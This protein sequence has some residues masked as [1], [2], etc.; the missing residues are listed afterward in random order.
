MTQ[1]QEL[2]RANARR[3]RRR[4]RRIVFTVIVIVVLVPILAVGVF[5]ARFD[6]NAYKPQIEQVVDQ[7]L[8]RRLTLNG[9]L[10]LALSLT[11]TITAED[12]ALANPPGFSRPEMAT[13][14]RLDA[15]LSL[16]PLLS[17]RLA[18][19]RI[20][21]VRPVI[22]VEINRAGETNLSFARQ[23]AS[24]AAPKG[25]PT[26]PT[27]ANIGQGRPTGH[28]VAIDVR[29]I[30]I[31]DGNLTWQDDRTGRHGALALASFT[32]TTASST[33]PMKLAAEAN[34]AGMPL[35]LRGQTGPLARLAGASAESGGSPWPVQLAFT[36]GT[37]QLSLD[38]MVADPAALRGYQVRLQAGLP[39][40]EALSPLFPGQKLPALH[41]V[42][43]AANL[44]DSGTTPR[45]TLPELSDV[46][47][48]AGKSDLG[49]VMPGLTL[50]DLS[51]TAPAL[52]QPCKLMLT[53]QVGTTPFSVSATLGPPA[54]LLPAGFGP[55][56]PAAP[57]PV[58]FQ[59]A[60]AGAN[61]AI[62]G[63]VTEPRSLAG[64]S[65]A[66]SAQVPDLAA[67]SPLVM[68]TLPSFA[69]VSFS[70]QITDAETGWR[71]WVRLSDFTLTLP[72][73]DLSG[74]AT[75]ALAGARPALTA[76]LTSK[77]L[78]LDALR[79]AMK[80]AKSG[81]APAA[82]APP[83]PPPV[84]PP[85][86][87]SSRGPSPVRL[88][89]DTPLPFATLK[90]ADAD[91]TLSIGGL[92]TGGIT[93]GNLAG[94][95]VLKDGNL[96]LAPFGVQAPGGHVALTAAVN[97]APQNP[98]VSLTIDAP[99]LA[100]SPLLK[101][102]G[103][104]A[105]ASGTVQ[106]QAHL[107]GAGSTPHAIASRLDGSLGV[108]MAGGSVNNDVIRSLLGSVLR[109]AEVPPALLGPGQSEVRCFA[110]RF[111]STNGFV[112]LRAF[113]LE[114][115]RLIITGGGG[116]ALGQE[117]LSL[118]LEPSY[119]YG[120]GAISL[121]VRVNG[122][123][124]DPKIAPDVGG[125]VNG[126]T[127]PNGLLAQILGALHGGPASNVPDCGPALALARF[128]APGP[129]APPPPP[130]PETGGKP[131]APNNPLNLLRGLFHQ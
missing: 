7:S 111:D 33:A 13:L 96:T 57:W 87:S 48:E 8:G 123:F 114:T 58:A 41:D 130:P 53:G 105:E 95:L 72:Q 15:Q 38:G 89:P 82:T 68:R 3:R 77:R 19:R 84:P 44:T 128:G 49:T 74:D 18:I 10:S 9:P 16:L 20:V 28:P 83:A 55:P 45:T 110:A 101:A 22:A 6:P 26:A 39:A 69:Q 122:T 67:L 1:E 78:D 91:L 86:P 21:L 93:Y 104:P 108:A 94:K 54:A 103:L 127:K 121:P 76:T 113:L 92:T 106:L 73:G 14:E 120:S 34:Y 31:T 40:L 4:L 5:V 90:A 115:G 56:L 52:D 112:D 51:F 64:A 35:T 59:A 36:L 125:A 126:V 61:L 85:V 12:V 124:L 24:G 32:A 75:L 117:T 37:A 17:G 129:A 119:Q 66:V 2:A 107:S 80:P 118:H 81:P 42:K 98:P 131:A 70:G 30:R 79:A 97:A 116:L 23:A 109:A 43:L 88:I 71:Q 60:G 47:L 11:P 99:A 62:S 25:P 29:A 102:F 100:L 27:P 46:S 50:S 63:S 65:L